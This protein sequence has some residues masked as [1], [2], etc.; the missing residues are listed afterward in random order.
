MLSTV[1]RLPSISSSTPSTPKHT[2]SSV[3]CC[4]T[5]DLTGQVL[6]LSSA[7][8]ALCHCSVF[9]ALRHRV[10]SHLIVHWIAKGSASH[11]VL[12]SVADGSSSAASPS[13]MAMWPRCSPTVSLRVIVEASRRPQHIHTDSHTQPFDQQEGRNGGRVVEARQQPERQTIH[14]HHHCRREQQV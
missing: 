9:H 11:T 4:C 12:S 14:R 1:L 5:H 3:L 13:N 8:L 2:M 10:S 7:P 6:H